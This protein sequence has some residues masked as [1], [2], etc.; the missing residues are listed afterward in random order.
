M[1]EHALQTHWRETLRRFPFLNYRFRFLLVP[2][3]FMPL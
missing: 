3:N 2:P 1:T